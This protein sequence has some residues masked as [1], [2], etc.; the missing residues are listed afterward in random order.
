MYVFVGWRRSNRAMKLDYRWEDGKLAAKQLFDALRT[1]DIAPEEQQY[2]NIMNDDGG[3]N[4]GLHLALRGRSRRSVIA[5]G[6]DVS[7]VLTQLGIAHIHIVHPAA[8]GAI[9]RKEAYASHVRQQL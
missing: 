4:F 9:R 3:F 2:V 6:T 8:R 5:M 7:H 1:C